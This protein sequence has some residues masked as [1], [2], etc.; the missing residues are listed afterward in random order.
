MTAPRTAPVLV[1]VDGS[2]HSLAALDFAAD[3][4][5]LRDSALRIVTVI[6]WPAHATGAPPE[7][8]PEIDGTLM[9]DARSEADAAARRAARRHPG[10]R[11]TTDVITGTPAG[12]L[13]E[14][15]DTAELL[16]VG[17]R[18]QGG[19]AGLVTGSAVT[20]VAMNARCPVVVA[21]RPR[22][23]GPEGAEGPVV[24]GFDGSPHSLRAVEFA[25][26]EASRRGVPLVAVSVWRPPP[27]PP[28]GGQKRAEEEADAA[29]AEIA[30]VLAD[31]LAAPRRDYP[32]LVVRTELIRST[33]TEETLVRRS[34]GA[35]LIV[36]GSRGRGELAGSVLGS[37]GQALV[38]HAASPVAIVRPDSA[39]D[40]P[41]L[42]DPPP[43]PPL[44]GPFPPR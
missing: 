40:A 7:R 15:S 30:R 6:H 39:A 18:G 9:R 44:P 38:H 43:P 4:A 21:R 26:D 35:A 16:V 10:L 12:V 32:G 2:D 27:H 28:N 20:Q 37:V 1:G 8:G 25:F 14:E 5:L 24:V 42:P 17:P 33:D 11:V 19:F 29:E 13:I 22:E 34:A 3:E 23:A 41:P 36:V 31:A